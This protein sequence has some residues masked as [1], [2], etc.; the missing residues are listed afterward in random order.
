MKVP[1][2]TPLPAPGPMSQGRNLSPFKALSLALL[3]AVAANPAFALSVDLDTRALNGTNARL[4]FSLLDGDLTDDNQATIAGLTTDG[5]LQAHDC[6]LSCVEGGGSFTL[7]DTGGL[8]Q[9]LQDLVLGNTVHFSLDFSHRFAGGDPDRLVLSLLDPGTNFTLVTT[10]LNLIDA[11]SVQDALVT[12]DFTGGAGN[13]I[14]QA[15][16]SNPTIGVSLVPVPAPWFLILPWASWLIGRVRL[17]R[18]S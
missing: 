1:R 18:S 4:E 3:S 5:T 9:F 15:T 2:N 8:G 12:V 14:R 6:S 10:N 11:T 13:L 7:S 17:S 16:A